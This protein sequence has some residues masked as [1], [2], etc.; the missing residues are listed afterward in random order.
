[1]PT[2]LFVRAA[3]WLWLLFAVYLANAR[4][5]AGQPPYVF[6]LC[7]L[8]PAATVIAGYELLKPVRSWLDALDLR[9]LVFLHTTRFLAVF[10]LILHGRGEL[11][12]EFA[13][14]TAWGEIIIAAGALVLAVLPLARATHRRAVAVWNLV[15]FAGAVFGTVNAAR[16]AL[17]GDARMQVFTDLPFALLPTFLVPLILASHVVL[18]RRLQREEREPAGM[19]DED[20]A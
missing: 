4:A 17:G 6:A 2:P 7:L 16:V 10:F 19:G 3:V 5:L 20:E 12:G 14:P 13:L 11:P 18:F 8:V 9:M 15:G 1:M